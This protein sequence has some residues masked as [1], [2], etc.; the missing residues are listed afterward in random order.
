MRHARNYGPSIYYM[1]YRYYYDLPI[2]SGDIFLCYPSSHSY[3]VQDFNCVTYYWSTSSYIQ[4]DG[5]N[6]NRTITVHPT[7]SSNSYEWIKV[8]IYITAYNVTREITKTVWIGSP[9]QPT[10]I[11]GFCC[12]GMEF[13]SESTYTF[14]ANYATNQGVTQYN[15]VVAGGTILDGQGTRAI[16]VETCKATGSQRKYFDVDVRVGNSCGWSS[17]LWRTGY[18]VSGSGPVEFTVSPNPANSEVTVNVSDASAVSDTVSTENVFIHKVTI[19]DAYGNTKK[20]K[21]YQ[22]GLK[23]VTI[24]VS[25]LRKGL[26]LMKINDGLTEETHRLLI[27]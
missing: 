2:I 6:T 21:Q 4:I 15:W 22:S 12:N 16:T 20:I 9:S 18:V 27:Q 25:D 3:S 26:Y 19:I 23:A 8:S 13:G 24:N 10:G 5:S 1:D 17:Y 14:Y 7:S 11:I